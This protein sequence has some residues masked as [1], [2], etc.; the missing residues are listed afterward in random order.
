MDAP[1]PLDD[2]A[3]SILAANCRGTYTLPTSGLYP[4]QWNWD[5]A[6]SASG[7]ARF[8]LDRA[9]TELETLFSAQWPNGMVPHIVFHQF[10]ESY[11]PGPDAW[12]TG[13]QPPTSGI[14]QPPAAAT[15][16]RRLLRQ[17]P[18]A[19]RHRLAGVF[20]KI[21]AWHRWFDLYRCEH[22]AVAASHPWETGRD[23]APDWDGPLE[24]VD[25]VGIEPFVR[26]DLQ[27][28]DPEMRP[29]KIDYDRYMALVQFGRDAGW[30]ED[31]IRA[32]SPFRVADP[33]LTFI[34]LRANLDLRVLAVELAR[35]TDEIDRWI[36]RLRQGAEA[37][38]NP[39]LE[40]YDSYD[41]RGQ[42]FAGTLSNA[43][44]LC[45][46][47]GVDNPGM[48]A[49]LESLL[50]E[51]SYGVP[52]HPPGSRGFEPRRYWRGP[53]WAIMN[54]M[55]GTGLAGFGH[56]A[57]ASRIRCDTRRLIAGGGFSEYFD[58]L[59][60]SPAGGGSFSWTAAVWLDWASPS[61]MEDDHGFA[62]T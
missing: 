2:Q 19:G 36:A 22:G 58:P 28:V 6:F 31:V 60:G 25:V 18:K 59:D 45:W 61:T 54:M 41:L 5:S 3:R 24:A 23:N 53:V 14:T 13:H 29:T 37:L 51:V 40:A 17:D 47:A 55:I 9:W 7:I 52:S 16:A 21:L 57:L 43:S 56:H 8:D 46:Y 12:G 50:G 26:R 32:R 1:L 62:K 10:D 42:R 34:L 49:R 20:S 15:I 4:Y 39:D 48:V 35:P 27:H 38:W 33:T 44:F 11:F 30:D